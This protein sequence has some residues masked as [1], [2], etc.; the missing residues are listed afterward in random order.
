[1]AL[2]A[3]GSSPAATPAPWGAAARTE[4]AQQPADKDKTAASGQAA[5]NGGTSSQQ[6]RKD[7]LSDDER[8]A[9]QQL[10]AGDREVRAHEAAHLAAAGGIALGG[11]HFKFQR[12]PDGQLYAVGGDVSIDV[13]PIS[14]D[15]AAT[16]QKA[17][18]IRRAALAPVH[19][20]SQDLSVAAQARQMAAQAQA[21]LALQ[22][23]QTGTGKT[24]AYTSAA[25]AEKGTFINASA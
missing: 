9:L 14:G 6:G 11:A 15:P 21:E 18:Q 5:D 3:I 25:P 10:Q 4:P 22:G 12:G 7:S 24:A 8:R 1:M 19:P 2:S 13:S 20:S 16:V 23:K 17:E